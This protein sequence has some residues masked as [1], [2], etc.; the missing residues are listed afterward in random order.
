MGAFTA[1]TR[2]ALKVGRKVAEPSRNAALVLLS[3]GTTLATLGGDD[4]FIVLP[5]PASVAYEAHTK[6]LIAE[7]STVTAA[8]LAGTLQVTYDGHTYKVLKYEP[9]TTNT[10]LWTLRLEREI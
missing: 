2:I 8:I 9:P 10:E 3:N 1:P 7:T 5:V 6:L 4:S